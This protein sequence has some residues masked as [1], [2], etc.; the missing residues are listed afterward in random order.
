LKPR[1]PHPEKPALLIPSFI[2]ASLHSALDREPPSFKLNPDG[3]L[4]IPNP[5]DKIDDVNGI[6]P[7]GGPITQESVGGSATFDDAEITVK[8]YLVTPKTHS[9]EQ[10]KAQV[11]RAVRNL[12]HYKAKDKRWNG[13][14]ASR[15]DTFLI[16]W[17]GI[18]YVG[19]DTTSS[20]AGEAS[21]K[22]A[23]C[24]SAKLASKFAADAER[25]EERRRKVKAGEISEEEQKDLVRL[26][27]VSCVAV[28]DILISRSR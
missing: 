17:K 5:N 10:Q 7:T 14:A 15:I 20:G 2:H 25:E 11:T 12:V 9:I 19:E 18:E 22:Q 1:Y 24:G 4:M 13:R 8:M 3:V 23:S 28:N 16:G 27:Q 26:W 6:L 21:S